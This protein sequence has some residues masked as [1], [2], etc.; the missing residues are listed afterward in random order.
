MFVS[1]TLTSIKY[2]PGYTPISYSLR[3]N[4]SEICGRQRPQKWTK[5]GS[6]SR[7]PFPTPPPFFPSSPFPFRR[8]LRRLGSTVKEYNLFTRSF[9]SIKFSEINHH[10]SENMKWNYASF[11]VTLSYLM[12]EILEFCVTSSLALDNWEQKYCQTLGNKPSHSHR[13]LLCLFLIPST[14]FIFIEGY[15]FLLVPFRG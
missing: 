11:N 1:H 5:G 15:L 12:H 13:V 7:R 10:L 4:Q 6:Y 3:L 9:Y 14:P 8:L 2:R